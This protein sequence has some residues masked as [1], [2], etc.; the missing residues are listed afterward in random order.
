M[1][2]ET[3]QPTDEKAWL[4]LRT[5]DL[6]ST[7]I[8]ALFGCSPYCTAYELFFRKRDATITELE[9]SER[10]KWGTRL[11]TAIAEGVALDNHWSIRPMT[12]YMR[13]PE[14]RLGS[15]F[16]FAIE[17]GMPGAK[18]QGALNGILEVKNVDFLQFREGWLVDGDNIEAPPHIEFQAQHQMLVSG[19]AFAYIAALVSGNTVKLIRRVADESIQDA[20]K[21][22]ARE[23]WASIA[24]NTPPPP[25]FPR[26]AETVA[27][28]HGF[29]EPGKIIEATNA[30][31]TLATEYRKLSEEMKAADDARKSTKAQLLLEIGDAE[32]V[33][34]NGFNISAG[35]QGP[36]HVE[37]HER[38]G[39]RRFGV[40]FKKEKK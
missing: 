37:A 1:T 30:V 25:Q 5:V 39:F 27:R 14:L 34:G 33:L 18:E 7:E 9:P 2:R 4:Q 36:A 24:A 35:V 13:A 28:L 23:F 38:A 31:T 8:S 20:I 40:T 21:T 10:M 19:R 22:K 11:Q 26:D 17:A 6:T 29:A 12:E 3:I 15:S 16:D 32:K